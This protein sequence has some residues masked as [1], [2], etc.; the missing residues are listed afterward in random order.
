MKHWAHNLQTKDG[1]FL[2][3]TKHV[4]DRFCLSLPLILL[5]C[6]LSSLAWGQ[7]F[8]LSELKDTEIDFEKNMLGYLEDVPNWDLRSQPPAKESFKTFR[9]V[10]WGKIPSKTAWLAVDLVNDTDQDQT[11]VIWAQDRLYPL[12]LY[13]QRG[14]NFALEGGI[15]P[16][17]KDKQI[18]LFIGQLSFD[19]VVPKGQRI[20]LYLQLSK[21]SP[22]SV[23]RLLLS[24]QRAFN[25]YAKLDFYARAGI[26]GMALIMAIYNFFLF[27]KLREHTYLYYSLYAFCYSIACSFGY[28]LAQSLFDQL[29][30]REYYDVIYMTLAETCVLFATLFSLNFLRLREKDPWF[31]KIFFGFAVIVTLNIALSF[32]DPSTAKLISS[33]YQLAIGPLAILIGIR[34]IARGDQAARFYL[35]GWG[36]VIVAN[37]I[38]ILAR[39]NFIHSNFWTDWSI[40]IGVGIEMLVLSLAISDRIQR[41]QEEAQNKIF[42][43]NE[44]LHRSNEELQ[45]SLIVVQRSEA[46]RTQFFHNTSHELR[47]P[48]NG[49]LG[50]LALILR[51][52]AGEITG[53]TQ[54]ALQKIWR[55]ADSLKLQINTILDLAQ[56]KQGKIEIQGSDFD[57]QDLSRQI[58][59]LAEGLCLNQ[60][61]AQFTF[62]VHIDKGESPHFISDY[63]KIFAITRNL[64][65]NAIKF[66]ANDRSNIVSFTVH[67]R[68]HWLVL[69]VKD[70][71]IGIPEDM[72]EKIFEEF[73]QVASEGRRSYEGTGLGLALVRSFVIA[74]DGKVEL[75]SQL[76]KGSCFT[77]KIPELTQ[78]QSL[79]PVAPAQDE[80]ISI[81]TLDTRPRPRQAAEQQMLIGARVVVIDD[82]V[83]NCEIISALLEYHGALVTSYQDGRKALNAMQV[84]RPDIL[85]LDMMMPE[86]SGED[87]LAELK[88]E[89]ELESIPVIVITARA[90][91]E[92][93]L[94]CF[95]SGA[96]DYLAKPIVE[97][98]LILRIHNILNRLSLSQQVATLEQ[99]E[100]LT[101]LG[102]VMDSLTREITRLGWN[103]NGLQQ[104]SSDFPLVLQALTPVGGTWRHYAEA[105]IEFDPSRTDP[106]ASDIPEEHAQHRKN[107][108]LRILRYYMSGFQI[109]EEQRA[110]LWQE[111]LTWE[112]LNQKALAAAFQ[113]LSR[114]LT[115][116][117]QSH[118]LHE[119]LQ[120]VMLLTHK[121]NVEPASDVAHIVQHALALLQIRKGTESWS[122][123]ARVEPIEWPIAA[124]SLLQI[125]LRLAHALLNLFH[126]SGATT[127]LSFISYQ[128]GLS[129]RLHIRCTG[130]FRTSEAIDRKLRVHGLD[131]LSA[132]SVPGL[133]H[134]KRLAK[135][136]RIELAFQVSEDG[137]EFILTL[138]SLRGQK[139]LREVS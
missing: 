26:L 10:D 96:D 122:L 139:A 34:A 94:R 71:G 63:E 39:Y 104:T 80:T 114:Y 95:A 35:L 116:D 97:K 15:S 31:Y 32:W 16:A 113:I 79:R 49:I 134:A 57:I 19:F 76:G 11:L 3:A 68:K 52:Q 103:E 110:T 81:K 129:S 101:L 102:E 90:A 59:H 1:S 99:K 86:F 33:I 38:L 89:P 72:R 137:P 117:E 100:R 58:S 92:D 124:S 85:L 93:R 112:T 4:M 12:H 75:Q 91:E 53:D 27:I 54:T 46:T 83:S 73:Q 78:V 48:L 64:V 131:I 98:E 44:K 127:H 45:E 62:E 105:G 133:S 24:T 115:I 130:K 106:S 41:D 37:T 138:P 128:E 51:G 60:P 65:A 107:Q 42:A 40:G 23:F 36:T 67:R 8:P 30:L 82:H 70:Q 55:L 123:D 5:Q 77:I 118:H 56:S 108:A 43:L 47:T 17:T 120:S 20:S 25:R 29:W 125:L 121:E 88:A 18:D 119:L 13:T 14:E 21:S 22:N 132:E 135:R 9:E 111:L 136:T 109:N 7:S 87:V 66:T 61:R 6:L 28:N 84:E 74:L 126:E 69:E 2:R 50:Y